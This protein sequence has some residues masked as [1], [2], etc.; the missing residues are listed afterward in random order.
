M[1]VDINDEGFANTTLDANGN[2]IPCRSYTSAIYVGSECIKHVAGSLTDEIK[3]AM[4]E[5][6]KQQKNEALDDP[7]TAAMRTANHSL[8]YLLT[9]YLRALSLHSA[10]E[11]RGTNGLDLQ[12]IRNTNYAL[13]RVYYAIPKA[14]ASIE[15][16]QAAYITAKES[17]LIAAKPYLRQPLI[18]WAVARETFYKK[19]EFKANL[20]ALLER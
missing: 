3:K 7:E 8:Y 16:A 18:D 19:A 12:A 11:I 1:L 4:N 2:E 20:E 14:P 17:F 13:E 6:K 10:E 5:F 9:N 15:T